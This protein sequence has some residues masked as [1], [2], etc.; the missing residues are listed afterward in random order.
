M[1]EQVSPAH[2]M[3]VGMGF[4]AS[5]TV[6]SAVELELFTKLGSDGMTGPQIADALGLHARAIPDFPDALVA[7]QLLDRDG[8][9]DEARYRNTPSTAVFLD[10]TSPAYVGG[11]L[12]MANA[13]LY[14][15]WG[16][17]TEA[18]QTGA[19]QNEIKQT[20][21]AM[22]EELYSDPDRLEQFMNAMAG[23]SLGPFQALA[24]K[25]DFS[26]Y[27]TLCDVGGAT[28]QLSLVV[29]NRH[30]HMHCSSYDLPVVEPIA[31]R[32]IERAGL[33]DRVSTA[34]G[35][36]FA[37]PLPRAE[38][39]TMGLILHDWNLERKMQLV[40]AAY[41]AL[42]EGG[43][44]IVVENLIDDARRENAFGLLMSLNML[45]EFGDAFDFTGADFAGWCKEAGFKEID[46]VPLAGPASAGIAYK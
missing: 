8:E 4:F 22:F 30:R 12:E 5:K 10:K 36:F 14:P 35:D 46:V 9:G 21:K 26:K 45:I 28:G 23:I 16:D 44:F 25:F 11:I 7:L 43:A 34:S 2:I 39:I 38:V 42:P 37:E 17:L 20:G 19:P 1:S 24:E 6:L 33:S 27:E 18:L 40:K 32:T 15:F 29:A 41:D 3:Q 31:K 13:R